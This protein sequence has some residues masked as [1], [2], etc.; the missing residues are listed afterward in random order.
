VGIED[1][2]AWDLPDPFTAEL[3]ARAEDVDRL[4]HVNNAVYLAWCEHVAWQHAEAVGI[5]WQTWRELD[6]AMAVVDVRLRYVAPAFEGDALLGGNWIV[7]NDGRLRASRRFQILRPADGKTLLRGEIDYV[8]IEIS[9]G[10]PRRFPDPFRSGYAV[11]ESVAA[12]LAD[13]PT[14][15]LGGRAKPRA[16]SSDC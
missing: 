2:V 12:A 4:A 3:H 7:R 13:E 6:R 5:G 15:V 16:T 11:L 8:C 10:R 1:R 9:T 14:P